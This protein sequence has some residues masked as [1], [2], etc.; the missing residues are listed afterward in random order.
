MELLAELRGDGEGISFSAT[1]DGIEKLGLYLLHFKVDGADA[2][3]AGNSLYAKFGGSGIWADGIRS[4]SVSTTNNQYDRKALIMLIA[5]DG[6]GNA[7]LASGAEMGL[8][9]SLNFTD[10][11]NKIINGEVS[12]YSQNSKPVFSGASVRLWRLL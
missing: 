7:Y 4:V 2:E 6:L 12:L 11:E 8:N 3:N 10:S 1:F 9:D 5:T